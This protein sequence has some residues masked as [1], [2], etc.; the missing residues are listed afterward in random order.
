MTGNSQN[1]A[2]AEG[3]ARLGLRPRPHT[4]IVVCIVLSLPLLLAHAYHYSFLT[5]DAFISFRY[6]RNLSDGFGLVF[7]PGHERVEGYTNFLWVLILA[8]LNS[9]GLAPQ[10][11]SLAVGF[12]ATVTI[13]GLVVW[14]TVRTH[15]KGGSRWLLAVPAMYLAATRSV[16]VWSTGGLETR[17]FEVLV[18]AA[19]LR[20]VIEVSL[21]VVC[22]HDIDPY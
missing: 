6:A 8:G 16:A 17:L 21:Q 2:G 14:F 11:A 1:E 3:A 22:A 20:L 19:C 12:A 7:N 4:A 9:L 15:R 5:D 18:V 13:W 10:Y